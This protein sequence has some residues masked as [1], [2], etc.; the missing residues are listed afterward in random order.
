MGQSAHDMVAE[1][2]LGRFLRNGLG[3][4]TGTEKKLGW[5]P[6]SCQLPF[7][8]SGIYVC[9]KAFKPASAHSVPL[10]QEKSKVCFIDAVVDLDQT[11]LQPI[12]KS[13]QLFLLEFLWLGTHQFFP[14]TGNCPQRLFIV[15]QCIQTT[16][17]FAQ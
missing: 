12:N 11:E 4:T 10:I 8:Y 15:R 14:E 3:A 5:L 17:H 6:C 16:F 7:I 1:S 9:K 2:N 13:M